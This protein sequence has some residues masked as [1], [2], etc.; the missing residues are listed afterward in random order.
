MGFAT[1]WVNLMM[2]CITSITYSVRINGQPGGHITPSHGLRQGD[3]ISPFLFL[4]FVQ[5]DYQH[6]YINPYHRVSLE[7]FWLVLLA[8]G[9]PIYSLLT[10]ISSFVK[11]PQN[12]AAILSIS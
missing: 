10:T 9:F 4:F 5:R 6:S 12:N 8:L 11:Q 2:Q 3:P 7:V 1:K